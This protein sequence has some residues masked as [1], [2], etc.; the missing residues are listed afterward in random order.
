MKITNEVL[1]AYLACKTKARLK[2]AGESGTRSDYEAMTAEARLA[3][4][5]AAVAKLVARFPDAHRG[6]PVTAPTLKEGKP[7]LADVTLED[8]V[9][10]LRLDALKR[11]E[12]DSKLGGH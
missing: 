8:E 12:A 2:L 5:E 6:V 7:L 9:L 3:S 4:R 11:V 1:E 10:S